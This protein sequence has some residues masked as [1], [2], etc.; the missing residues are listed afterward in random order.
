MAENETGNGQPRTKE[1]WER[2]EKALEAKYRTLLERSEKHLA[3]SAEGVARQN[4]GANLR[5]AGVYEKALPD[6]VD[7]VISRVRF[8][9][10][11]NPYVIG[12][13]GLPVRDP[14]D[15]RQLLPIE[16]Y[17]RQFIK[18]RPWF[19]VN[20]PTARPSSGASPS[21]HP[22]A[23]ITKALA[24]ESYRM[25]WKKADPEG[26]QKAWR[27]FLQAEQEKADAARL[28]FR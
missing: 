3:R 5:A 13:D 8:T 14:A 24:D 12:D 9:D 16:V 22:A 15:P 10:D 19:L 11:F 1:D 28:A 25:E 17:A 26:Y 27:A 20:D 2:A 18:E 4:I 6:A 21:H 7:Q 23:D